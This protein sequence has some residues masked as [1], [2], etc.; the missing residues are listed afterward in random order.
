MG[1]PFLKQAKVPLK[2]LQCAKRPRGGLA[3]LDIDFNVESSPEIEI[4]IHVDQYR[5]VAV[6]QTILVEIRILLV[7]RS[8]ALGFTDTGISQKRIDVGLK[9]LLGIT[10]RILRRPCIRRNASG[11]V[12]LWRLASRLASVSM[13]SSS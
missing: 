2:T 13:S 12:Q 10:W 5:P 6:V 9:R 8:Q 7:R 11:Q 3:T 4:G 1:L